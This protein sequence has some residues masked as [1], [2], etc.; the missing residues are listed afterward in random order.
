MKA[1]QRII[2]ERILNDEGLPNI[3]DVNLKHAR[4]ERVSF[5]Y[6]KRIILKYEW[7]GR[8][9]ATSYHYAL[10]DGTGFNALGIVCIGGEN[11]TGG[12]RTSQM[13]G[14]KFDELAVLARG[15]CTH[16]APIHSNSKLVSGALKLLKQ[17]APH[18]KIVI[19]YS[20][21]RAGEIGTIYQACNWTCIGKTN[22]STFRMVHPNGHSFDSAKIIVTAQKMDIR[23]K[24]AFDMY[25]SQGYEKV[26]Q[27]AKWRYV[28]ILDEKDMEVARRV[29]KLKVPY[30]KRESI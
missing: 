26:K 15:A 9:S 24:E 28:Y 27:P 13:L 14:C 25:I 11:C 6:A 8:M 20:D 4:I 30:P 18:K 23:W 5:Q 10:I 3:L 22:G 16:F 1:H 12:D 17:D 21:P 2:R 29:E 19:A 7:L